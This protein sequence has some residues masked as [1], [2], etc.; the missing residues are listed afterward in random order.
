MS[1][2]TNRL[3]LLLLFGLAI[4]AAAVAQSYNIPA[5]PAETHLL[6]PLLGRWSYVEDLHGP[7]H[8]KPTGTWTF[9]RS[10]DGFVVSDE[11]RTDNGSGGTAVVVETYRAYNPATKAGKFKTTISQ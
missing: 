2:I 1:R 7:E 4:T 3:T 11:F 6:D 9:N 5:V 8:F 10:A